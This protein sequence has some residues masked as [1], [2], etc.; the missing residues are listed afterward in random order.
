MPLVEAEKFMFNPVERTTGMGTP[1]DIGIHLS[2]LAHNHYL[3]QSL[4]LL[5]RDSPAA[6]IL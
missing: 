3:Q 4:S 2:P 5:Q 6:R 1:V